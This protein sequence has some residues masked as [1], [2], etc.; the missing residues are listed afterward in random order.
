MYQEEVGAGMGGASGDGG[1][2]NSKTVLYGILVFVLL[3]VTYN[4]RACAQDNDNHVR[5]S[6]GALYENGL[7][8]TVAYNHSGKYHNAWEYFATYYIKVAE[9]AE[10]GHITK[11]SFWHDYNTWHVG[12]AYKPCVSRGRNHHGHAR[13]GASGGS[14][15]H[16]FVGGFHVGYEHVYA[17]KDGWE[18]FFQVKEDVMVRAE[19]I[20]RTGVTVGVSVPL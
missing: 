17:L 19:D 4:S 2:W 10:A 18:L 16:H 9:D 1:G 13:I 15:L 20:F 8:A 14:D 11:Q 6:V 12:I 5:L 3:L 7:E